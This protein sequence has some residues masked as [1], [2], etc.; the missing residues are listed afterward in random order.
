L[1]VTKCIYWSLGLAFPFE[2]AVNLG[3]VALNKY[4]TLSIKSPFLIL[5]EEM[6]VMALLENRFTLLQ[7][8]KSFIF[9]TRS[10]TSLLGS[11][12]SQLLS[13]LLTGNLIVL[14]F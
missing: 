6:H 11:R 12:N 14:F 10:F 8:H 9:L 3:F 7:C 4:L 2:W 5:Y 13:L 1:F